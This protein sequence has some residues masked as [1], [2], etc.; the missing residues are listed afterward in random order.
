MNNKDIGPDKYFSLCTGA[1]IKD[2]KELA[3]ALDHLSDEELYEHVNHEKNDFSTWMK[4]VF[5]ECELADKLCKAK[6]RKDIQIELLK[7]IAEQS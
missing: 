7:H 3:F 4:D 1:L 6:D 2:I 5:E